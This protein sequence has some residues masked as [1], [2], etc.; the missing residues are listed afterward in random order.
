VH[1]TEYDTRL[2]AYAVL[3]NDENEILLTWFNG[4]S[5]GWNARWSL[6]G[7][8][9]EFD[10]GIEDAVVREVHEE[11]GYVVEVGSVLA[12]H[13]FTGPRS[14]RVSRP[15]RSQRVL[16]DARIV[17]GRLG[18]VEVGGTTDF[19]RWVPLADFPLAEATATI[20]DLAVDRVRCRG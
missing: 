19:A 10:E 4:G 8:G 17:G 2:A 16:F 13:H 18:T 6:P 1:F 5:G 7:G 11:T 3:V 14:S 15:F 20:V 9:V 12:F